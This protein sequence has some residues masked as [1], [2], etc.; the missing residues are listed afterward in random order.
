MWSSKR[1]GCGGPARLQKHGTQ[2]LRPS[3]NTGSSQREE[4]AV[5][6]KSILSE[7][8]RCFHSRCDI[9]FIPSSMGKKNGLCGQLKAIQLATRLD[10]IWRR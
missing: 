5:D 1:L 9:L 3:G 2:I 7:N 6:V 8:G 4:I 10:L